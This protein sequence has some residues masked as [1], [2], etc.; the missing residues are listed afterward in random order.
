MRLPL[1][2][3]FDPSSDDADVSGCE[4]PGM[5]GRRHPH[6]LVFSRD[7]PIK[8]TELGLTGND[9]RIGAERLRNIEMEIGHPVALV[10]TVT[11]SAVL[12]EDRADVLGEIDVFGPRYRH[13]R[14]G[15]E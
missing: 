6:E 12:R 9:D 1:G 5:Q 14:Q 10:R 8:L 11:L 3:L 13:H 4:R 15:E 2:A 7:A